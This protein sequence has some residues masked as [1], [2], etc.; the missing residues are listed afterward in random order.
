MIDICV[1]TCIRQMDNRN[2]LSIPS[3]W[4]YKSGEE[5]EHGIRTTQTDTYSF[6]ATIYSVRSLS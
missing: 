5:L 6:A 4:M 2:A 3:K 1:D